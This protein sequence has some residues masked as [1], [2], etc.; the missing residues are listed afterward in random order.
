MPDIFYGFCYFQPGCHH[1][2]LFLALCYYNQYKNMYYH[3]TSL[4]KPLKSLC[5]TGQRASFKGKS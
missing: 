5:A 3:V 2:S 4:P 1:V